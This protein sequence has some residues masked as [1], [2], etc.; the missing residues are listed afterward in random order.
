MIMKKTVFLTLVVSILWVGVSTPARGQYYN[1]ASAYIGS[2][3]TD[4]H[5]L[6]RTIDDTSLNHLLIMSR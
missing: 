2:K 3:T 5:L 4:Y 6:I 1:Y